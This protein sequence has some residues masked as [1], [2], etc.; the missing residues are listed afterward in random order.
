M[1]Q[2]KIKKQKCLECEYYKL[3]K[4]G[5]KIFDKWNQKNKPPKALIKIKKQIINVKAMIKQEEIEERLNFCAQ[6]PE[7]IELQPNEWT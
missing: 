6:H 1:F 5:K 2:K 7:I 4:K 3:M